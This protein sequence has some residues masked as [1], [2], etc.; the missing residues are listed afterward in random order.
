MSLA[1][2]ME[3]WD[4]YLTCMEAIEHGPKGLRKYLVRD[5]DWALDNWFDAVERELEERQERD[6]GRH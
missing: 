5:A 4:I 2:A 6:S 3:L 1:M